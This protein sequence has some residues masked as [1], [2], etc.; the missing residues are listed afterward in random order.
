MSS[1]V[2][3]FTLM[4]TLPIGSR[5]YAVGE[6]WEGRIIEVDGVRYIEDMEEDRCFTANTDFSLNILLRGE[7]GD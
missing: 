7:D 6:Y 4:S 2:S 3:T 1:C 5:F